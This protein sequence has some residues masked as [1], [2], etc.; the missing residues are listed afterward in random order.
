[1]SHRSAV[2]VA[3][4][5]LALP[6]AACSQYV[7]SSMV[8]TPIVMQDERLDFSRTVPPERRATGVHGPGRGLWTFPADYPRRVGDAVY[9]A[10]PELRRDA[11]SVQSCCRP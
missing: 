8:P 1:M 7:A 2:A 3:G 11:M 6:S 10:A 9:Q 4:L 5:A